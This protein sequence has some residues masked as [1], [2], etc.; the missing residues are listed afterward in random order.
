ML[1][2][3][4]NATHLRRTPLQRK[5]VDAKQWLVQGQRLQKAKLAKDRVL[6]H[7]MVTF[8]IQS[9]EQLRFK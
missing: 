4:A 7:K 2:R 3:V 6:G 9:T 8:D 5:A 1:G